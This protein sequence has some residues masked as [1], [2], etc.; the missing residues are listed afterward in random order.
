MVFSRF[1][2]F[3]NSWIVCEILHSLPL[4]NANFR[5]EMWKVL[6]KI[7]PCNVCKETGGWITSVI[8]K[9]PTN[10]NLCFVDFVVV[11]GKCVQSGANKYTNCPGWHVFV[12]LS[13]LFFNLLCHD[14]SWNFVEPVL[15]GFH[16]GFGCSTQ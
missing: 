9:S 1:K 15:Q 5:C 3:L 4:T 10:L 6:C 13:L 11:G 7:S 16:I 14:Y 12:V 8:A 2:F